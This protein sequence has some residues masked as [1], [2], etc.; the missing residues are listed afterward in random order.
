M[1]SSMRTKGQE[2]TECL[3]QTRVYK[4]IWTQIYVFFFYSVDFQI[5]KKELANIHLYIKQKR[6]IF[7]LFGLKCEAK[8]QFFFQNN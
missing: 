1:G 2:E 8:L 3:A 5:P 7:R 4:N 6:T